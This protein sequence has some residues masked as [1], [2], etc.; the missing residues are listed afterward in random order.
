MKRL[1]AS[2]GGEASGHIIV[3]RYQNTGDGLLAAAMLTAATSN[4]KLADC[5]DIEDYPQAEGDIL[6]TFERVAAYKK[7]QKEIDLQLDDIRT[8]GW[9]RLVVRPSGTEPKIRIM[10]E[11]ATPTKAYAMV[12]MARARILRRLANVK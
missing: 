11:A 5:D 1:G 6:T 9:G 10:A 12:A 3:G 7:L 2:I 4:K 8:Q